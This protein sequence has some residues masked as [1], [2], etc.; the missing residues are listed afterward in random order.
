M[1][2]PS[3][4]E[5]I[6][7]LGGATY[8]AR[9]LGIESRHTVQAWIERGI[10]GKYKVEDNHRALWRKGARLALENADNA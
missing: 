4:K 3:E 10:P 2:K 6:Q 7:A 9:K 5:I 1:N 8:V